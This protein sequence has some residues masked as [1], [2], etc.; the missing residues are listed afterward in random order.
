MPHPTP[1][2]SRSLTP[3]LARALLG[4]VTAAVMTTYALPALAQTPIPFTPQV[5]IPGTTLTAQSPYPVQ[6][7]TFLG[8]VIVGLYRYGVWLTITAAIFAC[9]V[10]GLL[11]MMAG[12]N[13]S[14]VDTAKR[15]IFSSLFGMV[16]AFTS[17]LILQGINPRLLELK[18]PE[19]RPPSVEK[20]AYGCCLDADRVWRTTQL[21][22]VSLKCPATPDYPTPSDP[23][24]GDREGLCLPCCICQRNG[25][26]ACLGQISPTG[27]EKLD[28]NV[29]FSAGNIELTTDLFSDYQNCYSDTRGQSCGA[30][31]AWCEQG[32]G[33]VSGADP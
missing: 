1:Q 8:Q 27:C 14:R 13:A 16:L 4:M 6:S 2:K 9:M 7:E 11:W 3:L 28:D 32:G 26:R 30:Y 33:S 29:L 21:D 15:M 17:Y 31:R 22:T 24:T 5:D 10:G 12:G 25:V 23:A 20:I 18:L 19:I